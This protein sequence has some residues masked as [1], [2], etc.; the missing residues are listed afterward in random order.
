MGWRRWANRQVR[1]TLQRPLHQAP[2]RTTYHLARIDLERDRLVARSVDSRGSGDLI[3]MTRANG[4]VIAP[5]DARE[6]E[7]GTELPALLWRD[8]EYR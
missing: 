8:F 4:F 3:S 2:G 6:I 7:A 1:A 5:A